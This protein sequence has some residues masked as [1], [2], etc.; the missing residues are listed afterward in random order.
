MKYRYMSGNRYCAR[1]IDNYF[2]S[3]FFY[4]IQPKFF[5]L[6]TQILQNFFQLS[7]WTRILSVIEFDQLG[8]FIAYRHN[9][10]VFVLNDIDSSLLIFVQRENKK[11]FD[12]LKQQDVPIMKYFSTKNRK[13]DHERRF[14]RYYILYFLEIPFI[15]PLN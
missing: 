2:Q 15:Q 13:Y 8:F 9:P 7:H 11:V 1:N 12:Y 10:R 14:P 4:R 5:S 6:L 3:F